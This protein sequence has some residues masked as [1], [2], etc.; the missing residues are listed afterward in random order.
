LFGVRF[1]HRAAII[2]KLRR[3]LPQ[4]RHDA[5][6]IRDLIAAEAPDIGRA[7]H[8]LFPGSAIFLREG[9]VLGGDSAT[10][11]YRKAQDKPLQSHDRVLS[12]NFS[13]RGSS[14][15]R[16]LNTLSNEWDKGRFAPDNKM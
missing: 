4:A 8:L 1:K 3:V 13:W 9:D 6:N 10:G 14:T 16:W 12:L 11:R 7:G 15:R 5:A 2:G